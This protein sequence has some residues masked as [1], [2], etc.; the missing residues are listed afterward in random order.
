MPLHILQLGPYPPPEGGITRNIL[1]IRDEVV[2][3]G[4]RCSII[5]T[6]RSSEVRRE[7]DVHHP[8]SAAALLRLLVTLEYDVLHLHIGGDVSKRVLTLAAACGIFGRNRNVLTL[9]SGAYPG[10]SEAKSAS[11]RSVRGSIFRGFSQLIAVNKAIAKVF[12]RSGVDKE[13]INVIPP[14]SLRHPDKNIAVPEQL[15]AFREAHSPLLIS[16]GGLEKDYDPFF[17]IEAMRDVLQAYPN[18]GLMIVGDGSM[19]N[20]VEKTLAEKECADRVLVCGNV[21]H[22]VTL[23]LIE[24]ADVLLR[25]TLFDGDAISVREA[26]FLGTP[27][28]ATDNG[29]RP[30]GVRLIKTNDRSELVSE[31]TKAVAAGRE[32]TGKSDGGANIK[33]VV[34]I[35][36]ELA[37]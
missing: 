10:T 21:E 27:V 33:A 8:R 20:A 32:P 23:H 36:E 24:S 16:V 2:A 12:R 15:R 5:A 25:T 18:A 14:Y 19:R 31:L 35:Y 34:D 7:P 29:M 3:R 22:S 9:H 13:R 30:K 17:Q 4:H 28:V 11:V 37:A 6:S 1:A 26:L